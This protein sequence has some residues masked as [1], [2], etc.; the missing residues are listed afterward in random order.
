MASTH[1]PQPLPDVPNVIMIKISG[2]VG[3]VAF[4]HILHAQHDASTPNTTDLTTL[5]TTINT[6]WGTNIKPT[7]HTTTIMNSVVVTDISSRTGA[8]ASV[9]SPVQTGSLPNPLQNNVAYAV[10]WIIARRY[11]GGHP[12]TYHTG[13]SQTQMADTRL[14]T[15]TARST[16]LSAWSSLKGSIEN[17]PPATL[18]GLRLCNVSYYHGKNSDG[19]PALRPSPL[20]DVITG[21][22]G[23]SR[24]DSQRRRLGRPA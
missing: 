9:T 10:G 16:I 11:R 17:S 22:K 21:V 13:L 12:R 18:P 24:V 8:V 14:L 5:A 15:T 20:V 2:T 4:V 6:S 7:Q 23:D 1:P 19:T 3:G